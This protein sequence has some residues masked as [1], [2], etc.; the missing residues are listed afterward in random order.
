VRSNHPA[1][2]Y[3]VS[4][5]ASSSGIM[6]DIKGSRGLMKDTSLSHRIMTQIDQVSH[7]TIQQPPYRM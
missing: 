5:P 6:D 7:N 3:V 4:T 1:R 2:S